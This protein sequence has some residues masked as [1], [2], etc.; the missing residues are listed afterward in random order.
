M[1]VADLLGTFHRH[2]RGH[3]ESLPREVLCQLV[4]SA[5]A[6]GGRLLLAGRVVEEVGRLGSSEQLFSLPAGRECWQLR[7]AGGRPDPLALEA[8]GVVLAAWQ[9]REELREARFAERRRLW[10]AEGLRAMV[11]VLGG[12]LH[13][14]AV[15]QALLFHSMALLDARRGEVWLASHV[16]WQPGQAPG[17]AGS[18]RLVAQHGEGVLS[19][20]EAAAVGA[21]LQEGERLAVPIRGRGRILGVLALAEREVRGG[22]APFSPADGGTLSLFAAQAGLAFEAILAHAQHLEQ[23]KLERELALAASVQRHLV[24]ELPPRLPGWELAGVLSPS[25]QVGGDLYDLLPRRRGFLVALFDVSG[26]GAAAAL[27]AASLQGALRVAATFAADLGELAQTLDRHLGSLWQP[28]QFATASLWEL[29]SAGEVTFLAAGHTPAILV[30]AR[31]SP[32]LLMPQAPP[33]GLLPEARFTQRHLSLQEG[34]VIL[35]ATDGVVE[36][37][38]GDGMELGLGVVAQAAS[39]WRRKPLPALLAQVMAQVDAHT[40]GA[41][42]QDDRTLVAFRRC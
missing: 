23:E 15:A 38:S 41:P 1:S 34:D 3:P 20:L 24:P 16:S 11:E 19:P 12:R 9:L 35:L 28:H 39:S 40:G 30:P 14:E 32:I 26:K 31:G 6:E 13:A 25:R 7:L 2:M 18:F 29:G 42:P 4:R 21:G 27:L 8:A 22:L 33:L 36:A 37:E 17:P 10:E 5:G